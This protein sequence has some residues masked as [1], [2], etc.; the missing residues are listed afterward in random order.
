MYEYREDD[1]N[2]NVYFCFKTC[3]SKCTLSVTTLYNLMHK[4]QTNDPWLCICNI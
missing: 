2:A 3:D 1:D 4:L